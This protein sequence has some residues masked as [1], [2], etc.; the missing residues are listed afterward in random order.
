MRLWIGLLILLSGG[1]LIYYHCADDNRRKTDLKPNQENEVVAPIAVGQPPAQAEHANTYDASRDCLYRLYLVSTIVGVFVALGGIYTIYQQTE[2]TRKAAEATAKS[3]KATE[4]SVRLLESSLRQWLNIGHWEI[5]LEE[6]TNRLRIRFHVINPTRLP[7]DLERLELEIQIMSAGAEKEERAI[8]EVLPPDNPY[9][10]DTVTE[11]GDKWIGV[12][13]TSHLVIVSI[14][15]I[16]FFMD[17]KRQ[18]WEQVFERYL[19][20]TDAVVSNKPHEMIAPHVRE[21]RNNLQPKD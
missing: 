9:I 14:K 19:L 17:A 1:V 10:V 12:L 2:A 6:N 8:S 16:A 3:A 20:V 15:C 4:D 7:V 21:I 5:W 18:R 13:K 11:F